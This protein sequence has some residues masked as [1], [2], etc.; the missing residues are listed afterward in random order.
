M[1]NRIRMYTLNTQGANQWL[2]VDKDKNDASM[3]RTPQTTSALGPVWYIAKSGD[4]YTIQ[5]S[6]G[7]YLYGEPEGEAVSLISDEDNATV[8][9]FV[10]DTSS[11]ALTTY[12]ISIQGVSP[13]TYLKS[14][15]GSHKSV[16]LTT[17]VGTDTQWV[18]MHP[19]TVEE[20]AGDA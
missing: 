14:R 10:Q 3:A 13:T 5:A 1:S 16:E 4:G 9:D 8:W 20:A 17:G 19:N 7:E 12:Q 11:A 18:L 15:S 6:T 2:A